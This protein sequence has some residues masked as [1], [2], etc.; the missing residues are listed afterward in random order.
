M[1]HPKFF[2]RACIC[3]PRFT[4]SFP[5]AIAQIKQHKRYNL[6]QLWYSFAYSFYRFIQYPKLIAKSR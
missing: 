5:A 3:R 2:A 1:Q 4:Q 6:L